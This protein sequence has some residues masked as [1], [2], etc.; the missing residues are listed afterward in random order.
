MIQDILIGFALSTTIAFLAYK[1]QSLSRDGFFMATL[2]GTVIYTFGTYITFTSLI[3]F[4]ISSSL[5]TKLHEKKDKKQSKGRNYKQVLANSF[6][7]A[8]VSLFYFLSGNILFLIAA[9]ISVAASNSDTW[10][11]EIGVLSKGKTYSI[12]TFKEVEKGISG[13]ISKL[14]TIASFFGALFIAL[15]FFLTYSIMFGITLFGF[16]CLFI[17]TLGGFVG[18][19]V[20]SYLGAVMQEKYKGL[21]SG[22]IVEVPYIEGEQVSLVSGVKGITNDMVNFLSGVAST[23]VSMLVLVI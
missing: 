20:D 3:L 1:K 19:M 16:Y 11:S 4:F 23:A 2:L 5:I 6:I 10:A 12:V 8:L 14:G 17:I 18:C 15:T 13:A 21:T 22:R 9:N 7:T